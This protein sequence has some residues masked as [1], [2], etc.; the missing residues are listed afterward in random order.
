MPEKRFLAGFAMGG[1]EHGGAEEGVGAGL[2]ALA[3]ATEPGDDVGVEAEGELFFDRAI[4][5]IAD[6]IAPELF[7]EFW[8]VGEIDGAFRLGSEFAETALALG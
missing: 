6:G 7:A 2:V 4:K 3:V 1:A 5:R 8:D